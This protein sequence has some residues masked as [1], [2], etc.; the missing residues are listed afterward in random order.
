M[1]ER[2]TILIIED[3]KDIRESVRILLEGEGFEVDEAVNG[4]EGIEKISDKTGLI[5]LDVM[6][7][8]IS[9]YETCKKIRAFSYAPILF[10]TAKSRDDEKLLGFTSGGDDYLTKPFSYSELSARVKALLRRR[11]VYDKTPEAAGMDSIWIERQGIK[12][13]SLQKEVYVDQKEISLTETEY[14]ILLLF[15]QHPS[16]IFSIKNI[17]ESIWNEEFAPCFSNTVM[18]HIRNLRSK[19]E[20]DPQS[21]RII[22]TVWGKGYRFGNN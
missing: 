10:L 14:E 2:K 4:M 6:M 18:V 16:K 8:G 15:M 3:D 5:I 1:T 17:Y 12:I 13:N 7:P 21:P 20:K 22:L 11:H 19:I 9:G